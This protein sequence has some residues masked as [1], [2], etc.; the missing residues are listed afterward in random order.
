MA[1]YRVTNR[2]AGEQ[3]GHIK[4]SATYSTYHFTHYVDFPVNRAMYP[5]WTWFAQAANRTRAAISN[6][7]HCG[8]F[9]GELVHLAL[10]LLL[11]R[12]RH[13]TFA[14]LADRV[15]RLI[16]RLLKTWLL[17]RL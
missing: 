5:S 16:W 9:L 14:T 6:D 7:R 10:F 1:F 12:T 13:T 17:G 4:D 3:F 15:L 11:T 2:L 8:A